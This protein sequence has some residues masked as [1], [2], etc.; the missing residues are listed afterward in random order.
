MF[1]AV[2][3]VAGV[4]GRLVAGNAFR[5]DAEQAT[6]GATQ[7]RIEQRASR[8]YGVYSSQEN[9]VIEAGRNQAGNLLKGELVIKL[10]S[11]TAHIIETVKD[12]INRN[13]ILRLTVQDAT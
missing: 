12:N 8:G 4:A 1:G 6:A 11:S 5:K 13:G 7:P 9:Q 10:E 2:A 3:V